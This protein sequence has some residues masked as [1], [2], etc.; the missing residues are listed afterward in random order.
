MQA[1]F[2]VKAQVDSI[3]NMEVEMDVLRQACIAL[4][5]VSPLWPFIFIFFLVHQP[6]LNLVFSQ[7]FVQLE[8]LKRL[9]EAYQAALDEVLF[10]LLSLL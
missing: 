5:Q 9:P 6:T 8:W 10:C 4:E 2:V 3:Y 7:K 1:V